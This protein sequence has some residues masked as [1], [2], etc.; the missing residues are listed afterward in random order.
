MIDQYA[1][2]LAAF[3]IALILT[4]LAAG[5]LVNRR[6]AVAA[7]RPRDVHTQVTPRMGGLIIA[8]SFWAII[9]V[10]LLLAPDRL[11][12]TDQTV[13]GIDRNLFGLLLGSLMLVIVGA[14]DDLRGLSPLTKLFGQILAAAMLPL[15][16][17]QI[18]W[19]AQPF[20]GPNIQLSAIS[21]GF[22]AIAWIV[23]IINVVNFLDGLDGLAAGV[24]G[25]ALFFLALLAYAPFVHQPAL[26]LLVLILLG[27]VLGFLPWNWHPARIFLGDSGSYLLGY[28]LGAAAI[29]SGGKLATAGLVLSLP[30]LDAC[31]AIIRRLATGHSPFQA[32]RYHL[33]QRLLDLGLPQP[34]IVV[35]MMT[36]AAGFGIIALDSRTTGK[37]Q[38]FGLALVLIVIILGGVSLLERR[39]RKKG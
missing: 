25:I 29:M 22:I 28:I 2:L 26:A 4:P 5:W 9:A 32:D 37:V 17:V 31:W 8:I 38:A 3:F 39:R 6:I 19:L 7:I 11:H 27:A 23:L 12:F 18:H 15:F 1:A 14:I 13:W 34:A 10:V 20:G 33:H 36:I 30:I 24:S 35:I 16:G 21:D